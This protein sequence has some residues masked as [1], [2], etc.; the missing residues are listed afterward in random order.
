[1]SSFKDDADKRQPLF[2][3]EVLDD[4][5]KD[6]PKSGWSQWLAF[7][8]TDEVLQAT[9]AVLEYGAKKY[10]V[11]SWQGIE[12]DRYRKAFIRHAIADGKFDEE[13]GLPHRWHQICNAVFL[14]WM[15][16]KNE[17]LD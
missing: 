3:L 14:A 13:S 16:L 10:K 7:V 17:L 12:A 11:N 2:P 5:V 1:M 8:G 4:L 15:E 9:E 6:A